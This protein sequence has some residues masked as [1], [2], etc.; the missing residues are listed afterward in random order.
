MVLLTG[1]VFLMSSAGIIVY[2]SH[3]SCTGNQEVSL[4]F[5]PETC[6][7]NIHIHHK[8]DQE[9]EER[10]TGLHE[11]HECSMNTHDCGCS[12]PEV[13]YFK[14]VNQLTKE[15]LKYVKVQ[16]AVFQAFPYTGF[17]EILWMETEI[18]PVAVYTDPPPLI[19]SSLDFVVR[20]H[21]LK[22]PHIA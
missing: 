19:L 20:L 13:K 2:T 12:S 5:T 4:Y 15:E 8:H 22:I 17:S 18:H 21:K 1:A 14:L 7:E 11:C 16:P 10:A 3:C 9:G 6:A